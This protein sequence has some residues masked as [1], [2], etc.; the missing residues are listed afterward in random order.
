MASWSALRQPPSD[1]RYRLSGQ[2]RIAMKATQT[3]DGRTR[4]VPI[5]DR[6]VPDLM[7]EFNMGNS[8]YMTPIVANNV[9]YIATRTH[10]Y[11]IE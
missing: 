6:W 2:P 11:A 8:I 10:L 4:F 1:R 3:D 7:N 9:L 5:E